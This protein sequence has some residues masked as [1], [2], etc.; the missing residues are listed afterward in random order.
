MI[1]AI[2]RAAN[3]DVHAVARDDLAPG[4]SDKTSG[5]K[6]T[7]SFSRALPAEISA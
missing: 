7:L 1:I 6:R 3:S 4:N 2:L 5:L